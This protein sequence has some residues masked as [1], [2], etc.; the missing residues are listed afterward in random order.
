MS[1][2]N[3]YTRIDNQYYQPWKVGDIVWSVASGWV[4][5]CRITYVDRY[6]NRRGQ[7]IHNGNLRS[8]FRDSVKLYDLGPVDKKDRLL[9]PWRSPTLGYVK[10]A[11]KLVPKRH[12]VPIGHSVYADELFPNEDLLNRYCMS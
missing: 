6:F 2:Y 10:P 12:F 4:Q 8:H 5:Q 1:A 11:F 3:P 9:N 7:Y